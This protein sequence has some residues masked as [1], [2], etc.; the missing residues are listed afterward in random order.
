MQNLNSAALEQMKIDMRSGDYTAI[1]ELIELLPTENL[2]EYLSNIDLIV[3]EDHYNACP[4][5]GSPTD[6]V[7]YR[8][9]H[10]VEQCP[11]CNKLFNFW[12]E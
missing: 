3:S 11:Q 2:I 4:H 1:A 8:A 7:D 12:N 5:D 9:G 6:L 10:S